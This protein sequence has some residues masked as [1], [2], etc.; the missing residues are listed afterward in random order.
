MTAKEMS[1]APDKSFSVKCTQE[2]ILSHCLAVFDL[3]GF[4]FQSF[5]IHWVV[6]RTITDHLFGK[7]S[8]DVSFPLCLMWT[9]W[10]ERNG[11]TFKNVKRS[12]KQLL[13]SF[14]SLLFNWSSVWVS[15]VGNP[16]RNS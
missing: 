9:M 7:H 3:W 16:L 13:A 10:R 5:A 4:V 6:P 15:L 11:R 1:G 12:R 8:S 2:S 14:T